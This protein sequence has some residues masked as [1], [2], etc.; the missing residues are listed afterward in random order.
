MQTTPP[1]DRF[2]EVYVRGGAP[3]VIGGPQPAV[4]ELEAE[5]EFGGSVLDAGC[6]AGEH[7]IHLAARGY[8]VLGVDA[9]APAVVAALA[10][11]TAHRVIARFA[12]ADALRLPPRP[13]YDTVLD[14]ALFHI[15]GPAD[16]A[17]YAASLHGACRPGAAL[18]LLALADTGPVFGPRV[19]QQAIR[20][21]FGE[22]WV[23]ER[24]D[25]SRYRGVV[26]RPEDAEAV[27][28]PVGALVDLPAWLARIRRV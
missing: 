26:R 15:F 11:A 22:G 16:R 9:S 14:S 20:D 3:W 7:T 17:R 18:H 23:V 24:V 27:G 6:G 12:V 4:V 2:D 21:A 5:G 25:V 8:D 28:R 19:G 10:N 13:R 1:V